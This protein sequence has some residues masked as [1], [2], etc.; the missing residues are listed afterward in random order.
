MAPLLSTPEQLPSVLVQQHGLLEAPRADTDGT[1]TYSDVIA[2]GVYRTQGV[3]P[4]ETVLPK[5]R[6]IGGHVPHRDG[7]IVVTGR[8]VLH[9]NG[10]EQRELH[11]ADGVH[12]F[13]DLTTDPE[14]RVLAGALRFRPLAG[15]SPVP[16][17]VWRIGGGD[18]EIVAAGIDWPNGIAVSADGARMNVSDTA[19]GTVKTFDLAAGPDA[20]DVFAAAPRGIPDGMALDAEGGLWL[21]LGDGGI[22]RFES[23]GELDELIDFPSS[24]VSSLAFGGPDGRD[25]FVTTADGNLFRA[26][27]E[28]AGLA[29]AAASA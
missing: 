26:R 22:A 3:L 2:G 8:T 29:V 4:P 1:V 11:A 12:G 6:G 5:R 19:A 15:E 23:S 25:V 27:A 9:V 28:V 21:A 10:D 17:E 16:G 14:G 13:N 7:G 20:G 18:P 24:F